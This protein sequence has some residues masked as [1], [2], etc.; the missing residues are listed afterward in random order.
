MRATVCPRRHRAVMARCVLLLCSLLAAAA[1]DAADL[2]P[3]G[4]ASATSADSETL[5][6]Q[7]CAALHEVPEARRASC[8]G[9]AA[10]SSLAAECTRTLGEALR[11]GRVRLDAGAVERCQASTQAELAGCGWVTPL[12]PALAASCR[13]VVE[14]L[15]SAGESCDAA[16]DCRPGLLCRRAAGGL[17]TC[18]PPTPVGGSCGRPVDALTT[19]T[20][21]NDLDA[22]HPECAGG[23]CLAGRCV[24]YAALGGACASNRQC[25]SG[26]H[27]G[28]GRCRP[29]PFA[30][31]G[32]TCTATSCGPGSSCQSGR[33]APLKREGEACS[34]AFEC[35]GACL[36][37]VGAQIG[38]CGMRC[39]AFPLP[40][41]P[42]AGAA[43]ALSG[44]TSG[45]VE[46]VAGFT[47]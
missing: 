35:E 27:C 20:R 4:A 17:G 38:R 12:Q 42:G 37:D 47:W 28:E 43:G 36:M 2:P 11:E 24:A 8:C 46:G 14:G 25:A 29:E 31:L 7:L 26:Q 34:A 45:A 5:A 33:C 1:V 15:R 22:R 6:H 21:A 19:Y 10:G 16:L 18:S 23:Y 30:A 39:E 32:A 3:A 9:R 44:A 13:G 40:A 41:S